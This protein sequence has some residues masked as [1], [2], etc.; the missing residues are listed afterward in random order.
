MHCLFGTIL[1]L[2][3]QNN[4]KK[5]YPDKSC[6]NK[7]KTYQKTHKFRFYITGNCFNMPDFS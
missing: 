2:Y 5:S 7:F 3:R 6:K 1:E 4:Y